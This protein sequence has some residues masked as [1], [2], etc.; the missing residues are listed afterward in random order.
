ME[1]KTLD[2][3]H[4]DFDVWWARGE[5]DLKRRK[6]ESRQR[7]DFL[8]NNKFLVEV[9]PIKLWG[10]VI[11][12]FKVE[13]GKRLAKEKGFVYKLFDCPIM[14]FEII[15]HLVD[16]GELVWLD[17]YLEKYNKWMKN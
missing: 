13:A 7:P 6:K 4:A 2:E 5:A 14:K 17:R 9:K 16:N 10:S 8:V 1:E 11:V 12:K 15:K 3:I